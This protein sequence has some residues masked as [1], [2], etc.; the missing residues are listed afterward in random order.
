MYTLN[1]YPRIDY[2]MDAYLWHCRFDHI[3]KNRIN[4]L[5][6]ERILDINDCKSLS[7]CESCL[8]EKMTKSSFTEKGEWASNVLG[9][10]YSD[11]C[12]LMNICV[13]GGYYYF[14][15]FTDNLSRYGYIYLMKQKFESFKIFKRFHNEIEK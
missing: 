14:I 3:N 1:K 9:L 12:R 7:I 10:V 13:R 6:K 4:M 8:L 2:V 15:T 5:T 11:I